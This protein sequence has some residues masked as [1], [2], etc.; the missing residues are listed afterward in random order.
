MK[1]KL[2]KSQWE[3]IGNESGWR[4]SAQN[5]APAPQ[6]APPIAAQPQQAQPAQSAQGQQR[7]HPSG[8]GGGWQGDP[9]QN[10]LLQLLIPIINKFGVDNNFHPAVVNA[11]M[12]QVRKVGEDIQWIKKT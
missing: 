10:Q 9:T 12:G 5:I 8:I 7:K 3:K 11:L 6:Q 4:K 1:I 2:S